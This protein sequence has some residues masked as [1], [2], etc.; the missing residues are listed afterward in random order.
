MSRA[1]LLIGINDYA[2]YDAS[3]GLPAG[4]SDLRG[5][6][7]DVK[8]WY[9]AARAMG[10]PA[11]NIVVCTSPVLS[12]ADMP[13]DA[14]GTTFASAARDAI[15]DGVRRL[16]GALSDGTPAQGL[17]TWSGH[18][19][20]LSSGAVLCPSDVS[21]EGLTNA[22]SYPALSD[23][24]DAVVPKHALTVVIDACHAGAMA[25]PLGR[26]DVGRRSL[27][28]GGGAPT[29]RRGDRVLCAA[30]AFQT[31]EEYHFQ[32]QWHGAFT[33]ALTTLLGRW[34]VSEFDGTRYFGITYRDLLTR[35]GALLSAAAFTQAPRGAGLLGQGDVPFGYPSASGAPAGGAAESGLTVELDPG[36]GL[37]IYVISSIGNAAVLGYVMAVGPNN[38]ASGGSTWL[39]NTEYWYWSGTAFP[40]AGFEIRKSGSGWPNAATPGNCWV[41]P[42][43]SFPSQGG[44]ATVTNTTPQWFQL[45]TVNGNNVL[46][47]GWFQHAAS[48]N[49][50]YEGVQNG[51]YNTWFSPTASGPYLRF[52]SGAPGSNQLYNVST[53]VDAL[54]S[55]PS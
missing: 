6:L 3:V 12:A 22:I 28:V 33:W 8:S 27:G 34:G 29:F 15:L 10:I 46:V 41:Y 1:A 26:L 9:V 42:N 44:T 16:G 2:T 23:A 31:A 14:T 50:W 30:G 38:H 4:S 11:E 43:K 40:S 55:S 39:K 49:N 32:G 24:L 21:G 36:D 48:A 54:I 20:S 19:S 35:C 51:S 53:V 47:S 45:Q 52:A 17:L 25:S 37:G 18:G 7:N 5:G 13:I